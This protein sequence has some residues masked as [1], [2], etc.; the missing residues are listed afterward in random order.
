MVSVRKYSVADELNPKASTTRCTATSAVTLLG[1][2][3]TYTGEHVV[4]TAASPRKSGKGVGNQRAIR[5]EVDAH[6][7][8]A[9]R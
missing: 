3:N 6:G 9:C 4:G 5:Q 1:A 8:L 2:M 7:A